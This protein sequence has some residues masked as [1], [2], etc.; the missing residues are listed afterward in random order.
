[1]ADLAKTYSREFYARPTVEVARDLVGAVLCKRTDPDEIRAAMI[2][3][4]EAYTQDDPACHAFRGMTK[5][6]EVMFGPPGY[7]YVYFIY[8]MYFCLNVVT[9]PEGIPGAVLIRAIDYE[10]CD[11]PG[12]LCRQWEIDR[13]HNGLEMKA[14]QEGLWISPGVNVVD[15]Q[16]LVTKRIGIRQP[17]AVHNLWRFCIKDHPLVSCGL[18]KKRRNGD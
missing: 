1:M 15:A 10:G 3:E 4:V 2:V 13:R 17:S 11:G 14:S 18:N 6:N 7:A 8:G 9:E 16:I 12:K 5:R